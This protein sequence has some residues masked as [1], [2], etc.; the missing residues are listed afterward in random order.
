[1]PLTHAGELDGS[2]LTGALGFAGLWLQS[3]EN[4]FSLMTPTLRCAVSSPPGGGGDGDAPRALASAAFA[5]LMVAP[6]LGGGGPAAARAALRRSAAGMLGR[7]GCCC[8]G[9]G[10]D[11]CRGCGERDGAG[12]APPWGVLVAAGTAGGAGDKAGPPPLAPSPSGCSAC[13]SDLGRDAVTPLGFEG[14]CVRGRR[15]RAGVRGQQVRV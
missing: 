15:G 7:C 2:P 3:T 6:M 8:G 13:D 1:M 12:A 4:G 5:R 10:D 14:S 9:D 11:A